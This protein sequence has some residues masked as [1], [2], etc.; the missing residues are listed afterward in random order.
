MDNIPDIYNLYDEWL[1]RSVNWI[2][3]Y[4]KKK[5]PKIAHY[6][7][8]SGGSALG[9]CRLMLLA[10]TLLRLAAIEGRHRA[11]ALCNVMT[12]YRCITG[13]QVM[14]GLRPLV[15]FRTLDLYEEDTL[16]E[17]DQYNSIFKSG[18][19]LFTSMNHNSP[20]TIFIPEDDSIIKFIGQARS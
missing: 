18:S 17:T 6:Q 7:C 14:L 4:Y 20:T 8:P 1:A 3:K 2:S 15:S 10:S 19:S 12:G 13:E 9:F 16:E 5:L 11:V